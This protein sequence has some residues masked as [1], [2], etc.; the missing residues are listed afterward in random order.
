MKI[1]FS[2]VLCLTSFVQAKC[3]W[4]NSS[5]DYTPFPVGLRVDAVSQVFGPGVR[6][7]IE[8]PK[9]TI[10]YRTHTDGN[11]LHQYQTQGLL[12]PAITWFKGLANDP[13]T[14]G[15]QSGFMGQMEYLFRRKSERGV[16]VEYGPGLGLGY[17]QG[18][19][20]W[21][22]D[23]NAFLPGGMYLLPSF[24]LGFGC[25][26]LQATNEKT[27]LMW[28]V[29][30][31]LPAAFPTDKKLMPLPMVQAGITYLFTKKWIVQQRYIIQSRARPH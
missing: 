27:P 11:K 15:K 19:A 12:V 22:K 28:S 1:V 6:V 31:H 9:Q 3:Q 17:F 24:S 18:D 10:K 7:A 20:A 2:L 5:D 8:Y 14:K 23:D 21:L 4:F 30:A 16:F 13:I 29:R 25:D 26:L